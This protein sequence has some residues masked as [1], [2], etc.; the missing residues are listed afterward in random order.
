M[1]N[2]FKE[3]F[4]CAISP[5]N[6]LLKFT[7]VYI[8]PSGSQ[9]KLTLINL[10]ATAWFILNFLSQLYVLLN[11]T[12]YLKFACGFS[13][14]FREYIITFVNYWVSCT[15]DVIVH[16]MLFFKIRKIV[17]DLFVLLKSCDSQ[18]KLPKLNR[19]RIISIA[20]IVWCLFMVNS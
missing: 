4:L 15:F 20:F 1:P 9:R 13:F 16:L 18:L 12:I 14:P 10:W 7:G 8:Y 2:S 17:T 5:F 6:G 11:K 19:I 3:R